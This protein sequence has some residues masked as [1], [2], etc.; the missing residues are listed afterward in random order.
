MTTPQAN[1]KVHREVNSS[2]GGIAKCQQNAAWP[3]LCQQGAF[4]W[5]GAAASSAFINF[6][7]P[8]GSL[9]QLDG[10]TDLT[11]GLNAGDAE[12][13]Q[14]GEMPAIVT[15]TLLR[16]TQVHQ[17][18]IYSHNIVL[19]PEYILPCHS[20]LASSALKSVFQG[21]FTAKANK[22]RAVCV[23]HT[24]SYICPCTFVHMGTVFCSVPCGRASNTREMFPRL[25]FQVSTTPVL[26]AR[27][28]PDLLCSSH[29]TTSKLHPNHTK[30]LSLQEDIS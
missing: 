10:S 9:L 17:S 18:P 19:C 16:F 23:W 22:D 5:P 26:S 27:K 13:R 25:H 7:V 21:V 6:T 11:K 30:A 14:A 2:G 1:T 4:H 24:L 20:S 15:V 8:P 3:L 29:K 12:I 28:T